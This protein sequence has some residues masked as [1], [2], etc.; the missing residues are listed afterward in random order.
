MR[1]SIGMKNYPENIRKLKI[2]IYDRLPNQSFLIPDL[3]MESILEQHFL[4]LKL[5]TLPARSRSKRAKEEVCRALGYPVP[6]SFR[7]TQPR[8]PGQNLDV[9]VQSSN[10]LQIWNEDI[11]PERRYA[12]I[13]PDAEG[14]V[15]RVR[16]VRGVDIAQFDTTGTFTSK[17]QARM[18]QM[19]ESKLLSPKD[20][21]HLAE[22]VSTSPNLT[23]V[24]PVDLPSA[25]KLYTIADIYR[26]LLPIVGTEYVAPHGY[27]DRIRG[28]IIHKEVCKALGYT[29]FFDD[30]TFPDVKNQ[31]LEIKTQ[32]SPTIDLGLHNPAAELIVVKTEHFSVQANEIRYAIFACANVENETKFRVNA[33]YLVTG[34]NLDLHFP[35]FKGRVENKKLQLPLPKDFF[36]VK[37]KQA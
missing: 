9:Y 23:G 32:T 5:G 12:L 30:G 16:V 20:E 36:D 21:P 25:N 13:R 7:R 2:S 17:F 31:L 10:N 28:E 19:K 26:R 3:E 33:L 4:G 22:L 37:P 11:D 1:E 27:S 35:L 29:Q 34:K 6:R 24:Q 15:I 18:I 14:V 8:F